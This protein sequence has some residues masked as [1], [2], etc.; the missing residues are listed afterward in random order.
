MDPFEEGTDSDGLSGDFNMETRR[1]EIF[2]P[3][4]WFTRLHYHGAIE[5]KLNGILRY[6]RETYAGHPI[7]ALGFC[8]GGYALCHF[9]KNVPEIVSGVIAHP[10]YL[11]NGFTF[12]I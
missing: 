4:G 6:I 5:H 9:A 3:G 11:T 10:R 1:Q 8:W 2:S 7:S 12:P